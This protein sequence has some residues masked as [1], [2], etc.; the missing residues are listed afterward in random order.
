M[1]YG[2][3]KKIN[4]SFEKAIEKA[5][6]ELTKE[7]FGV[8]TEIDVRDTLKKK[9]D[10]EFDNYIIL[11]ACN[12]PFAHKSLL[13]EKEIGLLLPCN[14]IV[15][16]NEDDVYVSAIVPSVAMNMVENKELKIIAQEVENKLKKV[17]DNINT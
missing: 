9:L 14:V 12:P 2:Y 10:V 17:V 4:L 15:Y 11:G 5:R 13:V 16:Q 7:G 1:E 8:L 3:R 6:S